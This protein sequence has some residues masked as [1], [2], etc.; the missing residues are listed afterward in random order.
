MAKVNVDRTVAALL[1]LDG[2]IDEATKQIAGDAACVV[3]DMSALYARS[4]SPGNSTNPPGDLKRSIDVE[5]PVGGDGVYMARVGPTVE[6]MNPGP[7]GSIRNY[8]RIQELGGVITPRVS[9]RL[10]FT[11]Y[12]EFRTAMFVVRPPRPYMKPGREQS[13][14]HIEELASSEIAKAIA[15]GV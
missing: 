14:P 15:G 3:R 5:G 10:A 12:G 11:I 6:S 1:A 13:L 4:G 7:G 9:Q 2:R 8:G